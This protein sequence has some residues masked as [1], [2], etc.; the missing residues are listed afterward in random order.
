MKYQLLSIIA[1]SI[2][3]AMMIPNAFSEDEDKIVVLETASGIMVIQF[4]P[5]DA[6]NTV[7]N[8]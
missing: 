7:D 5:G 8:F 1:I 3:G 2:I 6:P 4:F